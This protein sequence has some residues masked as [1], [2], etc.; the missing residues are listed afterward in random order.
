[1]VV[2]GIWKYFQ[3]CLNEGA[4]TDGLEQD[5]GISIAYVLQML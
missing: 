3:F 5:C 1:M 4:Y 2:S